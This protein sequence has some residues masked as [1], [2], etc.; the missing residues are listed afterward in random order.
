MTTL[1][2]RIR[3]DPFYAKALEHYGDEK[4]IIRAGF[5]NDG[6]DPAIVDE[7]SDPRWM[8]TPLYKVRRPRGKA[9]KP[10][11][12]FSTGGFAP[13]HEGHLQMMEA[14]R[15]EMTRAGY[16]VIGGFLAP[17]HDSYVLGKGSGADRFPIH[18]RLE[19]L[20]K[21]LMAS[22][23]LDVDPWMALYT[24]NDLNFTDVFLRLENYLKLHIQTKRPIEVAYV[25]G[26]DNADFA[27]AFLKR[28][29]CVVVNRPGHQHAFG[30]IEEDKELMK[31]GRVFMAESNVDISSRQIRTGE[32]VFEQLVSAEQILSDGPAAD[33]RTIFVRDDLDWALEPWRHVAS[34]AVFSKASDDFVSGVNAILKMGYADA[35][36]LPPGKS[37]EIFHV[38]ARAQREWLKK[39]FGN[40][41]FINMDCVT[42]G[43]GYPAHISRLFHLSDRQHF[44]LGIVHRPDAADDL[45]NLP[46]GEYALIDDD[47]ATGTSMRTLES[48]LPKHVKIVQRISLLKAWY[49]ENYPKQTYNPV[50]I[51]DMRDVLVGGR[52]GGL[53]VECFN[54][55]YGRV[56][57]LAPYV[58]M[59]SRS[60]LPET[61]ENIV[62]AKIFALNARFF[63]A[64]GDTLLLRDA[65]PAFKRVM[66][67]AGFDARMTMSAFC[68]WHEKMLTHT[69]G[70]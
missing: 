40:K 20:K 44:N 8:T 50:N 35:D 34:P 30:G 14:A 52:M 41:P 64:V 25:F 55:A 4:A 12:L 48:Q 2:Q 39:N 69:A 28:G 66:L 13:V 16:D 43:A 42:G 31:T 53:V 6:I 38:P 3:R 54:G 47:I 23:W 19:N 27:R 59:H 68:A 17:A 70:K 32:R 65:D 22:D 61:K 9:A 51:I 33:A 5:F 63:T 37:I 1:A 57:Y 24:P 29:L 62:S 36:F 60:S 67:D 7:L 15:A 45:A 46:P 49:A 56:P 11:V 26:A 18:V 21:A 58:S 10:L